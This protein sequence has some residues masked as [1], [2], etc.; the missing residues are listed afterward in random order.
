MA[1]NE[2]SVIERNDKPLSSHFALASLY[3]AINSLRLAV[4]QLAGPP[5]KPREVDPRRHFYKMF[6]QEADEYDKDF[7]KKYHDDLNTTLVFV[8]FTPD[9][10][11]RAF[12][13]RQAGLFSAVAAAFIIDIQA[14][15]RPDYDEMSFI[16]LS[17][18][19]NAT[20]G[21][22]NQTTIPS[23]TGPK[24]AVVQV[25]SILFSSLA[26]ALLAAF[27]AMLGK[28]WLNFHV[29]GSFIDRSRHRELRMRGMITW[30]FKFVMECLPFAMQLSLLLLGYALTRYTWDL[31]RTVAAVIAAFTI[32]GLVFYAFLVFG[33]TIWK[34]CPFQT[35]ASI[36]LRRVLSLTKRQVSHWLKGTPRSLSRLSRLKKSNE[37]FTTARSTAES[38]HLGEVVPDAD[39]D[40]DGTTA[41]DT[42]CISTM[43]RM[44]SGSDAIVAV[45]AFIPEINWSLSARTIPLAQVYHGLRK[46]FEFLKDGRVLV[47]PGMRDQALGSAKALLYLRIQRSCVNSMDDVTAVA[48][49]LPPILWY[50]SK[51]DYDLDSTLRVIDTV[52]I[53]DKP[54]QW[55]RFSLSNSHFCWLSNILRLRAWNVRNTGNALTKDVRGFVHHAFSK[56]PHIP[57]R[58]MADCLLIVDMVVGVPPALDGKLFIKDKR[59]GTVQL[60][61]NTN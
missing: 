53:G 52:F 44:A 27:L 2:R 8:S 56:Y 1:A 32:F 14:E 57:S 47:R 11:K 30:R 33:A 25:Q 55:D 43:F 60:W 6:N 19:L 39:E 13:V 41:L 42:N 58:V 22:P 38:Y 24:P 31:S 35:P 23:F 15:L 12:I 17:M 54:I 37:S 7:H 21:I 4:E 49:K 45:T 10:R 61:W 28:Q 20:S 40:D 59:F 29:D 16:V 50:H 46:S 9:Q 36:I 51:G 18:L 26:S 48:P 3:D 5:S 34:T